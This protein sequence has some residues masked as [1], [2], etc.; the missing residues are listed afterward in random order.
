[1]KS[2]SPLSSDLLS[3]M[4]TALFSIPEGMAYAKLAGVNP[5]YGLYSG[6]VSTIFASLTTGSILMISTLTSA[7]AISTHSVFRV[8][9]IDVHQLD[10]AIVTLT[11]MIGLIMIFMGLFRLGRMIEY[12]SNAVVTGF[13]AGASLLILLGELGTLVGFPIHEHNKLLQV[14]HWLLHFPDWKPLTAMIGL[15]SILLQLLLMVIPFT[16]RIATLT[17]VLISSLVVQYF[18]LSSIRLIRDIATIPNQL[19]SL[20]LPNLHLMPTLF[21]GALS[22]SLIAIIQGAG[23][24]AAIPN[25]NHSTSNPSKDLIGQGIGNLAGSFFHSMGTGGS[26]SRTAISVKA[27]AKTRFGGVFAGFFLMMIVLAFGPWIEYIPLASIAGILCV[28]AVKLIKNRLF[29]VQIIWSTSKTSFAVMLATFLSAL[30]IPLQW[31]IFIGAILSFLFYFIA[32]PKKAQLHQWVQDEKGEFQI[33]EA[34][35]QILS[36]ESIVLDFEGNCFFAEVPHIKRMMPRIEN[37]H[38]SVIIFRMRGCEDIHS[39]FLKW[40]RQF[41]ERFQAQGNRLFLEGID[42]KIRSALEKS[43]I[44]KVVGEDS[45]FPKENLQYHALRKAQEAADQF[46]QTG[47]KESI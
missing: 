15:G 43:G 16:K 3:G 41:A 9:G 8:A 40:L 30:F 6:M 21:L 18:E 10:D 42:P 22:V 37:T 33:L 29:D 7:I 36:N 34:P 19:P 13:V 2:R 35:Q 32:R 1:M 12:V 17:V 24:S 20:S 44:I 25:P 4:V 23:V 5:I 28:I 14:Y 27:G 26:L 47:T 11:C 31:T 46:I 45:L 38:H 39:S